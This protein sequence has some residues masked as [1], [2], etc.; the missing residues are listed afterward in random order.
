MLTFA[1]LFQPWLSA[2][3]PKG[4]ATA[5]AFGRITGYTSDPQGWTMATARKVGITGFWALL[6]AAAI[7]TTVFAVAA[8]LRTRNEAL[9]HLATAASIAVALF[10]LATVLYLNSKAPELRVASQ[11]HDGLQ[12]LLDL[13]S[14]A[15][16]TSNSGKHPVAS[17]G[18][19][20]AALLA[21]VLAV[22]AAVAAVAQWLGGTS[23]TPGA[24]STE[25]PEPSTAEP[26][27]TATETVAV[28]AT[29]RTVDPEE[30]AS[31][32][33]ELMFADLVA[34]ANRAHPALEQSD[35]EGADRPRGLRKP[36]LTS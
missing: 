32:W 3:G 27:D 1:L 36:V 28:R 14:G 25:Q 30:S 21:A 13:A 20:P 35:S 6:A 29:S 26:A 4:E 7:I 12:T 19:E 10:V 34:H 8:Y 5:D 22:G 31:L 23:A 18:L 33:H 17:A 24:T 15:R 9:A 2:W 11:S 16:E